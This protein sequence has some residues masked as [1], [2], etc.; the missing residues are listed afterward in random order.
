M[1]VALRRQLPAYSP[2]TLSAVW[3]G[4]S[5][6][7]SNTEELRDHL[8]ATL[9]DRYH[10]RS[11]LLVDSGTNA[12]RLAL[13]GVRARR[14]GI[15][16]LPAYCCYDLATAVEGA[17]ATVVL[18][19]VDPATLGP[20]PASLERALARRPTAVVAAHLFGYAVDVGRLS[21]LCGE[22]GAI[23]IEDAAQGAGGELDGRPLGAFGSLSVLSFG[24]GKGM[25]GGGGG[26]LLA[27]DDIGEEILASAKR[28]LARSP[29][30]V[31]TAVSLSAQWALGR[32]A[33]FG[34]P[35]SIPQLRLGE[36]V[37]RSPTLPS[38]MNA[39]ALGALA[40]ALSVAPRSADLRRA[41]AERLLRSA[42]ASTRVRSVMPIPDARPGYLRLPLRIATD[43]VGA[44]IA[45]LEMHGVAR[46]YPKALVDLESLRS[47]VVNGDDA[48]P[49]ARA[50]AGSLVT[51]PTHELV[52]PRDIAALDCWLAPA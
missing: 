10:A 49:G 12:L 2:L 23:L 1:S 41:T 38:G 21:R 52:E 31:F 47:R 5:A 24:R 3:A 29:A 6:A 32:P 18:Y 50:L 4:M 37:Y 44:V 25:T 9:C 46:A 16:A 36:T 26:A 35:A 15:I 45:Q 8:S 40:V 34:L 30:G 14:D 43:P 7:L 42:R 17:D 28:G 33:L 11:A 19:D 22:A 39:G 51:F 48:F 27:R 20:D 13:A